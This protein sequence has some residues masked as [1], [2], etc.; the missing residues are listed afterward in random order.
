MFNSVAPAT[1][2]LLA[3]WPSVFRAATALVAWFQAHG[4]ALSGPGINEDV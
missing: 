3:T 2:F 4:E 1:R